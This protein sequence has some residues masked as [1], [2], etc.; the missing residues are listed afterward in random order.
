MGPPWR[1]LARIKLQMGLFRQITQEI[2]IAATLCL[3]LELVD[4]ARR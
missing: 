2:I 1:V 3:R 4:H